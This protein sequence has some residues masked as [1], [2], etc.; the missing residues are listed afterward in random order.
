M[1]F[2]PEVS[3]TCLHS[4][5]GSVPPD[6]VELAITTKRPG[7]AINATPSPKCVFNHSFLLRITGWS[8]YYESETREGD[9]LKQ[10]TA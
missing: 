10:A 8:G 7:E 6:R 9:S 4:L 1:F 3:I 5:V 2:T